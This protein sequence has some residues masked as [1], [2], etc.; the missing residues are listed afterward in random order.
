[1]TSKQAV[2]PTGRE[3]SFSADEIIVSKTDPRGRITYAN[4][5]FCRVALYAEHELIGQP[6]SIVRHP[7]MPR[8]VFKLLWDTI[9]QGQEVFALVKNLAKNGDHYWVLAHVTPSFDAKGQLAGY[10]SNRRLPDR[11]EVVRIEP[12]YAT[13]LAEEHKHADRR[14]GMEAG[15]AL[16]REELA[17]RNLSYDRFLF[18]LLDQAA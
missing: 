4:D 16:L 14:A 15:H 18:A 17:R 7:D 8:C 5:V 13:L 6:H 9:A 11:A 12:V 1:M 2:V 10:H 3:T